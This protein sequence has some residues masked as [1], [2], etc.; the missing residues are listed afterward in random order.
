MQWTVIFETE[1]LKH[2]FN[3][4]SRQQKILL[5]SAYLYRQVRLIKE[6]DSLYSEDLST[7]FTEVLGFVVLEDKEKLRNIVEVIDGRIPDTDEFSEQEGSYAQNL[8]IALRYLVCFLLRIDE[9]G[10]QKCVDMSL[11]NIDL[12]NYDVDENYDEAEVVAREAKII[13]VFI[14]RAIRYAQSKVC[15]IDTVKNIVGSDWV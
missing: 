10:L 14:E 5:F 4:L 13:A 3:R 15:D 9:S 11:Q 1:S 7:F 12:I 2:D 6:F 8:I